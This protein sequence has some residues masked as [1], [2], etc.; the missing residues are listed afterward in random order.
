MLP[1]TAAGILIGGE[2]RGDTGQALAAAHQH[3]REFPG[4][5]LRA[6]RMFIEAQALKNLGRTDEARQRAH[7]A[8]RQYPNGLYAERVR[9]F[10]T[11]LP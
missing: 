2:A 4:G 3:A 5:Q 6:E 9:K 8:L 1:K 11:E 7:R 10:L